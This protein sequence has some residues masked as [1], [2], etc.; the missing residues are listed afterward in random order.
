MSAVIGST[1]I[2]MVPLVKRPRR[3]IGPLRHGDVDSRHRAVRSVIAEDQL[4]V[5]GAD[6]LHRRHNQRRPVRLAGRA[7]QARK[8]L[9]AVRKRLDGHPPVGHLIESS[10]TSRCR[11]ALQLNPTSSRLTSSQGGS[12]G[13]MPRCANFPRRSAAADVDAESADRHLAIEPFAAFGFRPRLA[14]GPR[15]IVDRHHDH[16]DDHADDGKPPAVTIGSP[17]RRIHDGP[18]VSAAH[19]ES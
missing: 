9:A 10:S 13:N 3:R 4:T 15:S 18:E 17:T 1:W 7:V 2:T 8:C 12:L 16:R 6:V 19:S 11:S 14:A 5:V